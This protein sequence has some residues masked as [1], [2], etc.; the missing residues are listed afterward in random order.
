Y[1]GCYT[2]STPRVLPQQVSVSGGLTIDKCKTACAA[3]GHSLAGV[4]FGNECYCGSTAPSNTIKAPEGDCSIPC[5]GDS[6]Q[7]CGNA[8]RV[9][10]Y[11]TGSEWKA[12]GCHWDAVSPRLL[13]FEVTS[14]ISGGMTVSKCLSSCKNGGYVLAGVEFGSQCFCGNA[15][16]AGGGG[17][18]GSEDQCDA[19]CA[20]DAQ[21]ICG[22]GNRIN[23]F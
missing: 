5:E 3:Q 18:A 23:V 1:L 7:I 19:V 14:Q 12:L 20:G 6:S 11:Q 9:G 10:V 8:W 15:F 4:E 16:A 17:Q 22:G 2:D 21:G 13:P